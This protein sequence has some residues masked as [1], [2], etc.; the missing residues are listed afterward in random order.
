MANTSFAM[1][2]SPPSIRY[3]EYTLDTFQ[4]H[5]HPLRCGDLMLRNPLVTKVVG[6][7]RLAVRGANGLMP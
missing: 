3:H 4:Q 1:Q 2:A 6:M 5:E 7:N